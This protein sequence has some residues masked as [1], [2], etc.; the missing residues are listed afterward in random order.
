[1]N[2]GKNLI[3]EP[4]KLKYG[5]SLHGCWKEYYKSTEV[6]KVRTRER[7]FCIDVLRLKK[8]KPKVKEAHL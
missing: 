8:E 5:S 2:C 3:A 4:I 6:W 7:N 1:M